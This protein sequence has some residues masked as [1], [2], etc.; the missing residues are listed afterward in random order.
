MNQYSS[1]HNSITI[2]KTQVMSKQPTERNER[3]IVGSRVKVNCFYL[4]GVVVRSAQ[5]CLGFLRAASL[6]QGPVG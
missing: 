3:M 5:R 6:Y 1:S 2:K 4:D